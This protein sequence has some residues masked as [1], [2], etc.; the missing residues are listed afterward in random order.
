M[1]EYVVDRG[2]K[3]LS[4][5]EAAKAWQES[6]TVR[7]VDDFDNIFNILN[8]KQEELHKW[9]II[10]RR[11][12]NENKKLKEEIAELKNGTVK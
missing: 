3:N 8:R 2:L 9:K 7:I 1:E 10:T 4:L 11:L 6:S 12:E 5:E